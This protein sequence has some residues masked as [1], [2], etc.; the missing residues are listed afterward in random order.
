[1]ELI[2]VRRAQDSFQRGLSAHEI[3]AACRRLLGGR[4]QVSPTRAIE[5]SIG[6]YNSTY[7]LEFAGQPALILRVAPAT[8]DNS[9]DS[10]LPGEMRNGYAAAP[11]FATLGSAAPSTVGVDFTHEIVDRDYLLQEELPGVSASELI[12][13]W[14]SAQ[15]R[16]YY[17]ELGVIARKIHGVQGDRF[18]RVVEATATK[19]SGRQKPSAMPQ[20]GSAADNLDRPARDP[21]SERHHIT[22]VAQAA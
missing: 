16:R 13:S 5:L 7:R 8:P 19:W 14:S 18:G 3:V 12:P 6:T 10:D 1:M 4:T 22:D 2:E 21:P 15:R 11:F 9:Y 20:A 17:Y